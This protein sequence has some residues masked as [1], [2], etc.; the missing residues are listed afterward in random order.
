MAKI[1]IRISDK[2]RKKVEKHCKKNKIPVSE[3]VRSL[4][5]DKLESDIIPDV[6]FDTL[7]DEV[8]SNYHPLT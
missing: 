7:P 8:K 2:L 5:Q 3:F 4:I 6:D 1:D